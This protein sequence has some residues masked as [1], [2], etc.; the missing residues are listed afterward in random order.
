METEFD[1]MFDQINHSIADYI[2]ENYNPEASVKDRFFCW[3]ISFAIHCIERPFDLTFMEQL[4]TSHLYPKFVLQPS[5]AFYAE[6]RLIIQK[7]QAE[8]IIREGN[9]SQINQFIRCAI[10]SFYKDS[11]FFRKESRE[12]SSGMD[13]R[14]MLERN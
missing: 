5:T 14:N 6:T 2:Q 3:W 11:H 1:A 9:I 8:G 10:S 7:G 13:D 12:R 4:A